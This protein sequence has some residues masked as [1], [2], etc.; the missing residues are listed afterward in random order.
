M[1]HYA[2][3][4]A[5]ARPRLLTFDGTQVQLP[6]LLGAIHG[7]W[8]MSCY[9]GFFAVRRKLEWR[10]DAACCKM[11][12]PDS[13]SHWSRDLMPRGLNDF[14]RLSRYLSRYVCV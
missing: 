2:T 1:Q 14:C 3:A 9:E 10:N 12:Q 13:V 4:L 5:N 11:E 6:G 7:P 8:P